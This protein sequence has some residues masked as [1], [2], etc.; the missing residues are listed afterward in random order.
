MATVLEVPCW[1]VYGWSRGRWTLRSTHADEF[2]AYE[3]AEYLGH[4]Y[5]I[6]ARVQQATTKKAVAT[7]ASRPTDAQRFREQQS[8]RMAIRQQALSYY[9]SGLSAHPQR[10]QE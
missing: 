8:D 2:D 1:R 6:R 5:K 4:R 3:Q 9:K 7:Q 10:P